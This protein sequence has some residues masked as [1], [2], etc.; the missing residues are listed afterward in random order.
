[1]TA[2]HPVLP[3]RTLPAYRGRTIAITREYLEAAASETKRYYADLD[4]AG[5]DYRRP[6]LLAHDDGLRLGDLLDFDVRE[7]RGEAALFVKSRWLAE[8]WKNIHSGKYERG[9]VRIVPEHTD[10][11]TGQTY[12]P[13][14][15][16]FSVTE[17][18]VIKDYRLTDTVDPAAAAAVGLSLSEEQMNETQTEPAADEAIEVVELQDEAAEAPAGNGSAL[19]DLLTQ[20]LAMMTQLSAEVGELLGI[21][22]TADDAADAAGEEVAAS[23]SQAA[24]PVADGAESN[25]IELAERLE[26]MRGELDR[27]KRARKL[28]TVEQGSPG[29]GLTLGQMTAKTALAKAKAEGKTGIAAVQRAKEIRG[30]K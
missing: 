15:D 14:I 10:P 7:Y 18:P 22:P 9:S 27:M 30:V 24:P 5:I 28:P 4:A 25:V 6:V 20:L 13:F 8:P 3:A 26:S 12:G 29:E 17:K 23:E 11:Q 21:A 16:E 19:A 1:M 2:W